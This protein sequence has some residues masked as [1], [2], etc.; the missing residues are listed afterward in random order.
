MSINRKDLEDGRYVFAVAERG[1]KDDPD[2]QKAGRGA[3]RIPN[4]HGPLVTTESLKFVQSVAPPGTG[5]HET[6]RPPRPG[7]VV[8]LLQTLDGYSFL[9][10]VLNGIAT[11][12]GNFDS[13]V[14]QIKEAIKTE[15]GMNLPPDVKG[16]TEENR[17]GL[18]K[19]VKTVVEKAQ[20]DMQKLYEGL[21]SH[22][23][24]PSLAGLINNPVQQVTTALTDLS[25]QLD[26]SLIQQLPGT[27]FSVGSFLSLLSGDQKK[28]LMTSLPAEMQ[29]ALNNLTTLKQSEQGGGMPGNFMLGGMVNP[30]TFA[31]NILSKLKGI[32]TFGQL[33]TA[34]N[35]LAKEALDPSAL[36]GLD[37]V[38]MKVSGLFGDLEKRLSANGAISEIAS[39]GLSELLSAFQSLTSG[40]PSAHGDKMFGADSKIT[41]MM[42]RLKTEAKIAS[43]KTNLETKHPTKKAERDRLTNGSGSNVVGSK[44]F[45]GD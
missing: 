32:T 41:E 36:D 10:G 11:H 7:Q 27:F 1:H 9:T 43:T 8:Q 42:N 45:F 19:A 16:E 38:V 17:S 24:S 34:L 28:E 15:T 4:K 29:T 22:G 12:G 14:P 13:M 3:Y 20:K 33:D 31:T 39:T 26:R 30:A 18:S 37:D 2:P 25:Q 44:G 21:P 5:Q 40:I 23:A 6:P 35:Q